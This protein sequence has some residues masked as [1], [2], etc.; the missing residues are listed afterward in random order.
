MS[1]NTVQCTNAFQIQLEG[2]NMNPS[3]GSHELNTISIMLNH[4]IRDI[5]TK[6]GWSTLA[7]ERTLRRNADIR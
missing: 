4:R 6:L 5:S 3:S 7:A 2:Q 1:T